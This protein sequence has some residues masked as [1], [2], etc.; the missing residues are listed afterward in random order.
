M[1]RHDTP[2]IGVGCVVIRGR[3]I[4]LL[5]R[6]GAHG[7]GTWSTPGGHLDHGEAPL[8]CAARE[9]LEETGVVVRDA[10]FAGITNDVFP[11][12]RHYV[13]LWVVADYA[14]GVAVV[15]DP[16]ETDAV[17]WCA[18]GRLPENLFLSLDNLVHGRTEPADL[19]LPITL[20]VAMP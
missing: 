3:D 13:T 5:R 2:R 15:G 17:R 10:R 20:S 1:T 14:S 9:T 7:D 8:A 16:G 11:E 18:A 6:R 12:G 19:R 4:L